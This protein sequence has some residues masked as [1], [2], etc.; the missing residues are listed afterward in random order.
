MEIC[1]QT[2]C[3]LKFLAFETTV[4]SIQAVKPLQNSSLYLSFSKD[5][6]QKK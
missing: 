1:P 2:Q 6:F 4:F 3:M 5:F